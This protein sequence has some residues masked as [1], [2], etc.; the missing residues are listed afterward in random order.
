MKIL[1]LSQRFLYPMDTGGKIRTGKI[2]EQLNRHFKI[3]VTSNLESPKDDKY[4]EMMNNLCSSFV[5]VPWKEVKKHTVKFYIKLFFQIF[6]RYPVNVLNDYSLAIQNKIKEL[7]K[8]EKHDLLI[9]D[10]L[11]SSLICQGINEYPKVLFQHNVESIIAKRHVENAK[12]LVVKFFWWLQW[13]KM[14]SFE[15][16]FLFFSTGLFE[17]SVIKSG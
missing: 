6:S 5:A 12:Y 10:F 1:F 4:L 14:F 3:T 9:C 11:Q 16:Q 7:L 8:K 17:H 13:K 15:L 2:L